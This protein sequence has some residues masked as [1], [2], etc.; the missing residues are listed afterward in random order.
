MKWLITGEHSTNLLHAAHIR[1]GRTAEMN[2]SLNPFKEGECIIVKAGAKNETESALA[3]RMNGSGE[4][5]FWKFL[6]KILHHLS[7]IS[8]VHLLTLILSFNLTSKNHKNPLL[9]NTYKKTS[10]PLLWRISL[11]TPY[12][13]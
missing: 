11:S 1:V 3:G 13:L 12:F 6:R 2:R 7:F 8:T 9:L 4:N 10:M 5:S